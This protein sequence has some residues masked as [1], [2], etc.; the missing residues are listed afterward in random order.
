MKRPIIASLAFVLIACSS[1]IAQQANPLP[2]PSFKYRAILT[3][4][5]AVGGFVTEFAIGLGAY[6][7]AVNSDRKVWTASIIGATGGG[8]GGYLIGRILDRRHKKTSAIQAQPL[9]FGQN[10]GVALTFKF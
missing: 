5:A 9:I 10:K 7:D 6:D 3:P 4:S 2:K 1:A 8:V